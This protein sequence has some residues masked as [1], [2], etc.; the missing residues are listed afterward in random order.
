[1]DRFVNRILKAAGPL[2]L[3]P[4]KILKI[5]AAKQQLLANYHYLAVERPLESYQSIGGTIEE[6][7][8]QRFLAIMAKIGEFQVAVDRILGLQASSINPFDPR[9]TLG[10]AYRGITLATYLVNDVA[11]V[12]W[13]TKLDL[14]TLSTPAGAA[15]AAYHILFMLGNGGKTAEAIAGLSGGVSGRLNEANRIFQTV[16]Q[17]YSNWALIG[18]GGVWSMT[19]FAK[20]VTDLSARGITGQAGLDAVKGM[21][22]LAFAYGMYRMASFEATKASGGATPHGRNLAWAT[23]AV[24]WALVMREIIRELEEKKK[25]ANGAA[26]ATPATPPA[27]A[28][29]AAPAATVH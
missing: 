28:P 26:A 22:D 7:K 20:V 24:G 17:K 21:L 3:T 10:K 5:I 4:D 29:G 18:G 2:E 14:S 16:L 12:E 1:M 9:T 15:E 8:F 27:L 6:A 25:S 23:A 19:D 11:A 13:L